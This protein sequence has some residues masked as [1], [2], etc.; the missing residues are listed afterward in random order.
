M[1]K[2]YFF[3]HFILGGFFLT[4][5]IL[6]LT[7]FSNKFTIPLVTAVING[8]TPWNETVIFILEEQG[9][10]PPTILIS[11]F[12][13]ITGA[14]HILIYSPFYL[15]NRKEKSEGDSKKYD[16]IKEGYVAT[17]RWLEYSI[18]SSIMLFVIMAM[19]GIYDW[20]ALSIAMF[21]NVT[22]I[23]TGYI[24]DRIIEHADDMMEQMRINLKKLDK[25]EED[26]KNMMPMIADLKSTAWIVFLVG[27]L[28]GIGPWLAIFVSLLLAPGVPMFV[29]VITTNIA[30]LF[31]CFAFH[32]ALIIR[33]S[34]RMERHWYLGY[35][36]AI[37]VTLSFTAK[38]L[39]AWLVYG[40][41]LA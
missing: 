11:S 41:F 6:Q 1:N 7:L 39:L 19:S 15:P 26:K 13:I 21:S 24:I 40:A 20:R 18:T 29:V 27:S 23:A 25:I 33:F 3:L 5:G 10:L 8:S 16:L 38:T 4:Q 17:F 9:K 2:W 37:Y 22:M 14:F 32:A 36:E 35:K 34:F 28:A 30:S 31:F 12:L